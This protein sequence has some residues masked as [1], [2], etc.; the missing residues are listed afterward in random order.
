MEIVPFEFNRPK[1]LNCQQ[2][3]IL[4][5]KT[6]GLVE[7]GVQMEAS[8]PSP[9]DMRVGVGAGSEV[10]VGTKVG[11]ESKISPVEEGHGKDFESTPAP[12]R[13]IL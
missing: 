11:V 10:E 2:G 7:T 12:T 5:G 9:H 4:L 3:P 1:P 6:F 8:K 13:F